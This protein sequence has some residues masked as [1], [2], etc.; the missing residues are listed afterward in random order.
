LRYS[1]RTSADLSIWRYSS[2]L[3]YGIACVDISLDS[4]HIVPDG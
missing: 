4:T 2:G 1:L 3:R